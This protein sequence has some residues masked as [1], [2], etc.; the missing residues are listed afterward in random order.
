MKKKETPVD[1]WIVHRKLRK[2]IASAR[3]YLK[4][5]KG[6]LQIQRQRRHT[7]E[8]EWKN[9]MSKAIWT[10]EQFS[11]WRCVCMHMFHDWPACPGTVNAID[12]CKLMDLAEISI[13]RIGS[14]VTSDWSK[15]KMKLCQYLVMKE[16][17]EWYTDHGVDVDSVHSRM[18][19][20]NWSNSHGVNCSSS[21]SSASRLCG[22]WFPFLCT[23]VGMVFLQLAVLGQVHRWPVICKLMYQVA[24]VNSMHDV[25]RM[26]DMQR[27]TKP[28]T[29]NPMQN[30]CLN[31]PIL[32]QL[33]EYM[34]E[35][36]RELES[37]VNVDPTLSTSSSSLQDSLDSFLLRAS[38]QTDYNNESDESSGSYCS[39]LEP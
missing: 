9:Q 6:E 12:W 20:R 32:Q 23:D 22:G 31:D 11:E 4:K 30:P 8:Q 1:V 26:G 28:P 24:N 14:K 7:F 37:N 35:T 5:K 16:L 38:F 18:K 39:N 27:H 3:W 25:H 15:R 19:D 21:T 2:K 36:E 29:E 10:V 13:Q 34:L 17:T 33:I